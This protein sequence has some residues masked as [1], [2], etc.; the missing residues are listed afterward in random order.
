MSPCAIPALLTP[1][2][3]SSWCICVDSRAINKITVK[4][5]FPIPRLNDTLDRLEGHEV[6]TK[7]DLRSGYH[8]ICIRLGDEWKTN[9]KTKDGLYEWLVMPFGLSNAPSTF[10]RLMNQVLHS[11]IGKFVVVYFDDI[12]IY[13]KDEE[14]HLSHLR[15]VLLALQANK[16]YINLKFSFMTSHLLF[17]R[18]I[19]RKDGI[20]VD[21]TKV[22]AIREWPTP[23]TVREVQSFHDLATFF[24]HFI[25]VFSTIMV[26]II[27][28]LTKYQF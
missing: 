18:F 2:K 23:K 16:L 12:L 27:D 4:C 24:R 22:K 3:D 25:R 26:A 19:V 5:H 10:M 28:R 14:E 7:L 13:S 8:Q 17:L 9:F 1:K 15:E 6:F 21:E 11:F 20:Q